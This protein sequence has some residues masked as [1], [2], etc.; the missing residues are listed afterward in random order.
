M[1]FELLLSKQRKKTIK[2]ITNTVI[3]YIRIVLYSSIFRN[4]TILFWQVYCDNG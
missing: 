3:I 2:L 1:H 4:M